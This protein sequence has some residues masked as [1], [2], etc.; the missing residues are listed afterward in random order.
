[1]PR[2]N[3][4][5]P[6]LIQYLEKLA[7]NGAAAVLIAASAGGGHL[8]TVDELDAWFRATTKAKMGKCVKMGLLRP[9]DGYENNK[10]LA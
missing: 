2:R 6:K 9:E 5:V 8:R 4:D 7:K 1:L 3:L 10:R